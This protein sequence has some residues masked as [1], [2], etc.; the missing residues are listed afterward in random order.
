VPIEKDEYFGDLTE[1]QAAALLQQM[2]D[3]EAQVEKELSQLQQKVYFTDEHGQQ[4]YK[5]NNLTVYPMK[6]SNARGKSVYSFVCI[7]R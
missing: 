4:Y 7:P 6:V 3:Q 2:K 5:D 1:E